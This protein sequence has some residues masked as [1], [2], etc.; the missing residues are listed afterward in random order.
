MLRK[1][2]RKLFGRAP[3]GNRPHDFEPTRSH[4]RG[5]FL[6]CARCGLRHGLK[7]LPPAVKIELGTGGDQVRVLY[8]HEKCP[9]EKEVVEALKTHYG[10]EPTDSF[11]LP[12]YMSAVSAAKGVQV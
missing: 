5:H 1:T 11:S 10:L 4:T 7:G 12:N 8:V 2:I 9:T 6:H 3:R